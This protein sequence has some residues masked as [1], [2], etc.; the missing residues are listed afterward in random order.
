MHMYNKN[1]LGEGVNILD[2]TVHISK[3]SAHFNL[4]S[5]MMYQSKLEIC[6]M[7]NVVFGFY[8]FII[9][10]INS[11]KLTPKWSVAIR[12]VMLFWTPG[13]ITLDSY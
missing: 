10:S 8:P 2:S 3:F 1:T 7:S 12:T 9:S 4:Y 5:H 13:V 6:L 11:K